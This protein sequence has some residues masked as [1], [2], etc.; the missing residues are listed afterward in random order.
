MKYLLIALSF[1]FSTAGAQ[2]NPDHKVYY[3]L[4]HAHTLISDGSGT[5]VEAYRMARDHG[6]H[7]FAITE[8][9]HDQS[10]AGAKDRK[11]GVQIATTP[12]LYNGN[13]NVSV[14][15]RWKDDN[16]TDQTEQVSIKPLIR[17][18]RDESTATFIALYG[19]EFSTISSS[20]HLNVFGLG[21]VINTE[22]GN[23]SALLSQLA[24]LPTKPIMQLNHPGVATDLFYKGEQ[25][26]TIK[27]MYNDYGID[28][29]DLGPH[30]KDMVAALD[31]YTHL[32][33]VLSGPAMKKKAVTNY[34][35]KN[36][37]N[38]YY[39][40]LKQ[41]FHISPSVGQDN[42][43]KTWGKTTDARV[44][45][46]ALALSENNIYEAFRMNRTF[47]TEDKNLRVILYV[48]DQ[49]M[50]SSI[51]A[52]EESELKIQVFIA[53]QDEDEENAE[54][55]IRLYAGDIEPELSTQAADWKASDGLIE[56]FTV[57]GNGIFQIPGIFSGKKPEFIYV[58]VEQDG[59]DLAWTAPVWLN[60]KRTVTDTESPKF[61]WT[62]NPSSRVYHL[63]GCTAIGRI[64]PENLVSG[65]NPPAGRNQHQCVIKEEV[66]H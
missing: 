48:N 19:Q 40:Y 58:R 12:A 36:H 43:Y 30:F 24:N 63:P 9:N 13:N 60:E 37:E 26:S 1:L 4:L 29:G 56:T 22:N 14:T 42:H 64:K 51:Q 46:V 28:A 61:F 65:V 5:P 7:F 10:E 59:S 27:K 47:A 41:G 17:A 33:E 8:H 39:F 21:D 3:G 57:T 62:S 31:P 66:D 15:R 25:A 11:D 20:N 44:G 18:A 34:N 16:G 2:I 38:D 49:L 52:A 54:Y 35:Y 50:G 53:D 55:E 6:L 45:I 32:I 23:I